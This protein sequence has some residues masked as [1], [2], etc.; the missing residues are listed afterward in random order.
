MR[1]IP[2]RRAQPRAQGRDEVAA[3]RVDTDEVDPGVADNRE[4]EGLREEVARLTRL[5][6]ERDH[7]A[8]LAA[9]QAHYGAEEVERAKTRLRRDAERE[10][11]RTKRGMLNGFLEVLDDLDRALEAAR[12]ATADE[13]VVEGVTLVRRR[14]LAK[15][16]ELDVTHAPAMGELFDPAC[17][18]AV[19]AVPVGAA[20]VGRVVAVVRE[21]YRIGEQVLRPAWVAVGCAR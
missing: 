2:I 10:I 6:A 12:Q 7:Q 9:T 20:E 17:H 13:A 5:L 19:S 1:Q 4:A 14:F 15:L 18:E 8:R 21:G 11:E 3:A 16:G